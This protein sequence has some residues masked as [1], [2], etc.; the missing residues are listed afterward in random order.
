ML[1]VF[2]FPANN[3]IQ[4]CRSKH[5]CHTWRSEEYNGRTLMSTIFVWFIKTVRTLSHE[6]KPLNNNPYPCFVLTPLPHATSHGISRNVSIHDDVIKWKHFPRCWP[7][8]GEFTGHRWIPRTKASDVELWCF[9]WSAP[10]INSSL[11]NHEA[12]DLGHHRAHYDVIV[13]LNDR[14]LTRKN[15][16]MAATCNW[17]GTW[18]KFVLLDESCTRLIFPP[19]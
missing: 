2:H 7:F 4:F 16:C 8:V 17:S 6:S 3:I 18:H 11:N 10:W 5:M 14:F 12:G 9:L 15:L 19:G 13:M 1:Y